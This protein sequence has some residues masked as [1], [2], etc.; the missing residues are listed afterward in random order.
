MN[1]ITRK[2]PKHI[3]SKKIRQLLIA[4]RKINDSRFTEDG[5]FIGQYVPSNM[6]QL[7]NSGAIQGANNNA[8]ATY[9][10]R[11]IYAH[12][13]VAAREHWFNA[14]CQDYRKEDQ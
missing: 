13:P 10:C 8:M 14:F 12:L 9:D 4:P 2:Y 1:I 11:H 6:K 7:G 3:L 5:S